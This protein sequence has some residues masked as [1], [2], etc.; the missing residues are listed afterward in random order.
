[1][2]KR[3]VG[4]L[5]RDLIA[6]GSV[7][8]L[9]ITIARVSTGKAYYPMQFIIGAIVFFILR[10][11]FKADLRAGVGIILVIFTSIFYGELLFVIF[12]LIIYAGLVISLLYLKREIKEIAKGVLL[13][14]I[15]SAISYYLV[16]SIFF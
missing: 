5:A 14:G 3:W 12:A 13:G 9:V 6:F 4:E 16:K 15:S 1:M 7:P 2:Q 8:F 11:V 10:A